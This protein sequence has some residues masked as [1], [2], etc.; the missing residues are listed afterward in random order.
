M[1]VCWKRVLHFIVC[2][3]RCTAAFSVHATIQTNIFPDTYI[4]MCIPFAI[5]CVRLSVF[6]CSFKRLKDYLLLL[7]VYITNILC[8]DS[9]CV[10]EW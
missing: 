3:R 6:G 10:Y 7:F 5:D 4:F 9:I 2:I 1:C 8:M